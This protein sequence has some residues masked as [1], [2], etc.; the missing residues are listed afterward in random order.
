MRDHS[1]VVV[2]QILPVLQLVHIFRDVFTLVELLGYSQVLPVAVRYLLGYVGVGRLLVV[3]PMLGGGGGQVVLR[4]G[5]LLA[6]SSRSCVQVLAQGGLHVYVRQLRGLV[7]RSRG[8]VAAK[9]V[10]KTRW[11]KTVLIWTAKLASWCAVYILVWDCSSL[12]GRYTLPA[13]ETEDKLL[14]AFTA[15]QAGKLGLGNWGNILPQ[16]YENLCFCS[17]KKLTK[18]RLLTSARELNCR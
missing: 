17:S 16:F 5:E 14:I 3:L 10:C 9:G 1:V 7:L 18:G 11:Y 15:E 12:Q 13:A 2:P 6:T 8:A 4:A